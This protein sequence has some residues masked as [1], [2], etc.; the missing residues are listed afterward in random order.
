MFRNSL[1]RSLAPRLG[2]LPAAV[3]SSI[4][5][6]VDTDRDRAIDVGAD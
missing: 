1:L 2:K 5:R 3:S 4:F 6:A